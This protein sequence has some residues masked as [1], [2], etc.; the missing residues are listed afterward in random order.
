VSDRDLEGKTAVVTGG[1]RGIG[2][3]I[4]LAL[5]SRGSNVV[6]GFFRNRDAAEATCSEIEGYGVKALAIK[7]HTGN[8]EQ[9]DRLFD[10]VAETFGRCDVFVS[11]AASGVNR[12]IS[13]IDSRSWE[14]TMDTNA[15]ALLLGA[16][17]CIPLMAEGGNIVALSSAG[18]TRVLPNYGAVGASK[19]AIEALIR[20]LA[21]ELGPQGIR[22][23]VVSPG[24]VET[25]ALKS[26]PTADEMRARTRSTLALERNVTPDDVADAVMFLTSAKASMIT[27]QTIVIDGGAGLP[28]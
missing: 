14:W 23:N 11:N 13:D 17:R 2:R 7:V 6:A 3:A 20:Y 21:V 28:G 15:R 24:L 19:A 5:A 12:P 26:F 25:D 16:R 10:T 22:A 9:L 18:S 8:E 4:S 1:G 27:G